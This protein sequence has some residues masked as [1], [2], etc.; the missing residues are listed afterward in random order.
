MT[1]IIN[2][3]SLTIDKK[4]L[5]YHTNEFKDSSRVM[6][7]IDLENNQDEAEKNRELLEKNYP[8]KILFSI[9]EVAEIIGSS[10]EFIRK[11]IAFGKIHT[12]DF[13]DRKMIHINELVTL[14]TY[15]V[16]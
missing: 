10:Y 8:Q 12:R 4:P 3:D 1:Q 13:G 16:K 15:G 9:K 11:K 2:F 14:I 5:K 6:S 7:D